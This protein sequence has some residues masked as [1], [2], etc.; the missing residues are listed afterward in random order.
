[1]SYLLLDGVVITGGIFA[2]AMQIAGYFFLREE[3][4]TLADYMASGLT[5]VRFF[6]HATLFG[7]IMGYVTWR[8]NERAFARQGGGS[9]SHNAGEDNA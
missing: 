5:W 3:S 6:F 1:V 4:Q 9:D 8:R 7:L 2:V